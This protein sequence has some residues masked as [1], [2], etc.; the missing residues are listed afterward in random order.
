MSNANTQPAGGGL[1]RRF[2]QSPHAAH[3]RSLLKAFS[4]RVFGSLDTFILATLISG[5]AKTGA[6]IA[7]TEFLTKIVLY[8]MHERGWAHIRWGLKEQA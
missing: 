4:W 6:A 8:Y 2:F 7:G 1:L 3:R 5:H